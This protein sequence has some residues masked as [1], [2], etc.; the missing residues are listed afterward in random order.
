MNRILIKENKSIYPIYDMPYFDISIDGF[1][2]DELLDRIFPNKEIRGLVPPFSG[3]LSDPDDEVILWDRILPSIDNDAILPILIC[4]DDQD[5]SCLT[6]V[7]KVKRDI[8][9]V[10]WQDFG[11]DNSYECRKPELIGTNVE[12]LSP[13]HRFIFSI[14]DYKK[15]IQ[16][17]SKEKK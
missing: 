5:Y 16:D 9:N 2:L 6:I 17:L 14:E 10:I 8:D 3:W 13:N 1:F 4:P 7:T 12:W 11:F 15:A